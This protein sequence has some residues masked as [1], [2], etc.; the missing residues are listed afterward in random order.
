[1]SLESTVGV[2]P[3]D[4]SS[5]RTSPSMQIETRQTIEPGK[6]TVHKGQRSEEELDDTARSI[7]RH[8]NH[9][10]KRV[11]PAMSFGRRIVDP[12]DI[13]VKTGKIQVAQKKL[14]G[15]TNG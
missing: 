8:T 14:H 11:K 2:L 5:V 13:A 10:K 4:T 15:E 9:R 7:D 6:N 12:N 3:D 1:M